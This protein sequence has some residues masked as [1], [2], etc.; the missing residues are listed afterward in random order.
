MPRHGI[1]VPEDE[2][3]LHALHEKRS[4]GRES[5]AMLGLPFSVWIRKVRG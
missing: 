2:R 5:D 4:G 3:K 1:D